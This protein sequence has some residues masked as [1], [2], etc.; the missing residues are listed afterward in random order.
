MNGRG[1][2]VSNRTAVSPLELT[3]CASW[4][5]VI[6]VATGATLAASPSLVGTRAEDLEVE[7]P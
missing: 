6:D 5:Q 1:A 2:C 4:L 7:Y 3:C